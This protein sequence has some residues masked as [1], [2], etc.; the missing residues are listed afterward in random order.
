QEVEAVIEEI[1][2]DIKQALEDS[3]PKNN[4]PESDASGPQLIS[5]DII[6][7]QDC[8]PEPENIVCAKLKFT[9]PESETFQWLE[10]KNACLACQNKNQTQG[11]DRLEALGF[12]LGQCPR[13][14][15]L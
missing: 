10:F 3:N 11:Q 9:T 1:F 12:I 5:C 14:E 15:E 8:G 2:Q 13:S 4:S 7:N 6:T